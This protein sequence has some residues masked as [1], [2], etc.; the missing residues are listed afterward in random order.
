MLE[1]AIERNKSVILATRFL[2]DL[3]LQ[4][5]RAN[6]CQTATCQCTPPRTILV[7]RSIIGRAPIIC[8]S[9][10]QPFT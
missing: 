1:H 2:D 8:D 7:H 9:C 10:R 6:P 3:E 4:N 5:E